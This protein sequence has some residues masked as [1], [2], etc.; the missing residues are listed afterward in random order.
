MEPISCYHCVYDIKTPPVSCSAPPRAGR[1]PNAFRNQ[2]AR[3]H[4]SDR[5][6]ES[7]SARLPP[8]Q[9]PPTDSQLRRRA[10]GTGARAR[11]AFVNPIPRAGPRG[12][13]HQGTDIRLSLGFIYKRTHVSCSGPPRA[14][15]AP[16]AFRNPIARGHRSD[17]VAKSKS[18]RQPPGRAPP[19][20][21]QL[22]RYAAGNGA[23][24]RNAFVNPIA[25]AGPP[26]R[27]ASWN[28]SPGITVFTI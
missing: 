21:S 9:A 22:R 11:N 1:A 17:R 18:A 13:T 16:N 12:A 10:A 6:D 7:K 3:R 25:R 5:V 2:K 20:D 24:A 14:G 19:T 15:C 4:R 27:N 8:G 26:A 23:R 28:R